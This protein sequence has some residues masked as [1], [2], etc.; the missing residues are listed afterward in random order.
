LF[1]SSAQKGH[2]FIPRCIF[3]LRVARKSGA[4]SEN[5]ARL[6]KINERLLRAPAQWENLCFSKEKSSS[7]HKN[8]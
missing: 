6:H 1:I 7:K 5:G 4:Q 8:N 2:E 3:T